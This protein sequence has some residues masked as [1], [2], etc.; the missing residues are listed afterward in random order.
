[1]LW[2][3]SLG[4]C[5]HLLSHS[6]LLP[7]LQ[8]H[9]VCYVV[10]VNPSLGV[11]CLTV[12]ISPLATGD[13]CSLLAAASNA[14]GSGKI[15]RGSALPVRVPKHWT[16]PH[17]QAPITQARMLMVYLQITLTKFLRAET[18]SCYQLR[19]VSSVESA[20]C[21]QRWGLVLCVT[22]RSPS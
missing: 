18:C 10:R 20:T 7:S 17:A 3:L 4:T 15:F 11:H 2:R 13:W 5:F 19:P 22:L 9:R 1:M 12:E 8:L 21:T 6:F 16:N 14:A